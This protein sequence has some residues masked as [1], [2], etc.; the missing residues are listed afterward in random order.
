MSC[1]L[2]SSSYFKPSYKMHKRRNEFNMLAQKTVAM[3]APSR[4]PE[5]LSPWQIFIIMQNLE[6]FHH[7]MLTK[8]A[9]MCN[10]ARFKIKTSVQ[11]RG[12]CYT[13]NCMLTA[14]QYGGVRLYDV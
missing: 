11:I 3:G 6:Y 7:K 9:A 1:D 5:E 13:Y 12:I 4:G 14:L 2:F 8:F 10:C